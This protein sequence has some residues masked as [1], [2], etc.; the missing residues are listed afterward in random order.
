MPNLSIITVCFN[1]LEDLK[2]TIESVETQIPFFKNIEHLIIDGN[3]KDGTKEYL[4]ELTIPHLRYISESDDG[5]YD[6]MNKV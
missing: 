6:A 1:A 4:K 2:K 3:S 5:I